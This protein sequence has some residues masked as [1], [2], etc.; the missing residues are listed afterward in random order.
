VK[1]KTFKFLRTSQETVS[2]FD[3]KTPVKEKTE[4]TKN[5][6]QPFRFFN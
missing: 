1:A 6:P 2:N 3:E 4:K 5:N